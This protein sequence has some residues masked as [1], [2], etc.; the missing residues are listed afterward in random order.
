MPALCVVLLAG[1]SKPPTVDL[2]GYRPQPGLEAALEEGTL[3]L[4]WDGERQQECLARFTILDGVPTV[5]E[6]AVRKE[7]GKWVTLGRNLNARIR[8]HDRG[9][10][11]RARAP[12]VASLGR[13][14]GRPPEPPR[15]G[16]PVRRRLQVGPHARSR[17]TGPGWRS[18]SP[19]SRWGLL[20]RLEVHGLPGDEP[21][22][23]GGRRQDGRALG[24]LH[25]PGRAEGLLP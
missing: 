8:R 22:A 3:T 9:A 10:A 23:T 5:R 15:G 1:A 6:L 14:L 24:R 16:S 20:G 18:H 25:L 13:V 2:T 4:R 7:G 12:G 19:G 11:H 17:R 21:A